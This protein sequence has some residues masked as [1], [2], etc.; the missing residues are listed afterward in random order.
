M[1]S[2]RILVFILEEKST[3]KTE[4][5]P[6][7]KMNHDLPPGRYPDPSTH[8][9]LST[10]V[11]TLNFLHQCGVMPHD[12]VESVLQRK[13]KP[14]LHMVLFRVLWLRHEIDMLQPNRTHT[15]V[16]SPFAHHRLH[17]KVPIVVLEWETVLSAKLNQRVGGFPDAFLVCDRYGEHDI[18]L[19]AWF[20]VPARTVACMYGILIS[21][22]PDKLSQTS[23]LRAVSAVEGPIAPA[24]PEGQTG[25]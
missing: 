16:N 18:L 23:D 6:C 12:V 3:D 15:H 11:I 2:N 14:R 10:L 22:K 17:L 21:R 20:T 25:L 24:G 19:G 8:L 13:E 5:N 9:K 1:K 7:E 4:Y